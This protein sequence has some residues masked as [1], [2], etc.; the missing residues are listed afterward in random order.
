MMTSDQV[1]QAFLDFFKEK[2]HKIIPSS[3]LIP[4]GDPT[5]LLTT[6]GMVQVKPYFLG[7][8]KPPHT[9]LASCQKCFRTT[10]IEAVG[11]STHLTFFEMLGN[12]SVGDYFKK[13]AIAWG[14]EFVTQWLKLPKERLWV[15]IFFDD[16]ES[17]GY[18]RETGVPEERILR[19]GEED[20]FWG[21]AGDSGPCGPCSEIHYDFGEDVGCGKPD[22]KPNCDCGRFSEIWNLVFTQYNQDKEGKR[23]PLPKPNIDTGMGLERTVA[24]VNNIPSVYQTEL[25]AHLIDNISKFAG[26]KYGSDEATD[27]AMRVVVEHGRAVTFLIADGVMPSNE[28]RGYVLRRLL[29]RAALF[30]R[31]LGLD[32]P[33]LDQIAG[34]TVGSMKEVYPELEKN[35]NHIFGVV[36]DEEERFQETLKTGLELLNNIVADKET[37]KFD[38]ISGVDAFRLYD[39]YGF[40]I[41][42]TKEI[43]Q[44]QG[45]SVDT[46]GFEREM[47]GQKERAKTAHTFVVEVGG[48]AV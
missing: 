19:F 36:R 18:W 22:C 42:L 4:K 25:F 41:E 14:W 17:F 33:F 34:A 30:G 29:R 40:P 1:R 32:K 8:A 6:A 45:L 39:T 23:T 2:E 46:E 21:P 7:E 16:D 37:T 20:N 38:E 44:E 12:F 28:K 24:A 43:A 11:D 9:R 13:E 5:L 10:D 31:R 48:G 27:K 35:Q 15:T 26:K 47:A 3:S